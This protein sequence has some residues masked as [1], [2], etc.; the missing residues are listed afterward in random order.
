MGRNDIRDA[1][2]FAVVFAVLGYVV[3]Q[4]VTEGHFYLCDAFVVDVLEVLDEG[5][6]GVAVRHNEYVFALEQFGQNVVLVKRHGALVHHLHRFAAGDWVIPPAADAP[7]GVLA[8]LLEHF[9]FVKAGVLAVVALVELRGALVRHGVV[10]GG[11]H[12]V[13]KGLYGADLLRGKGVVQLDVLDGLA[14]LGGLLTAF[15]GE[16]YICY[17]SPFAEQVPLGFRMAD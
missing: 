10:F 6:D 16:V 12:E 17:A 1:Q 7:K 13:S 4:D 2:F 11:F 8:Q 15:V 9:P 5:A 3:D 14:E